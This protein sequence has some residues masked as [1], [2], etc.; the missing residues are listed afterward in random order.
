MPTL[1]LELLLPSPETK[2]LMRI[3]GGQCRQEHDDDCTKPDIYRAW[4]IEAKALGAD[5]RKCQ[6]LR[7]AFEDGWYGVK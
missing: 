5:P 4:G 3:I 2:R 6:V 1:S 7:S